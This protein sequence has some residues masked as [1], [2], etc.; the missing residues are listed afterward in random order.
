MANQLTDRWPKV[1]ELATDPPTGGL[2]KAFL[3]SHAGLLP[4]KEDRGQDGAWHSQDNP[5]TLD[6][7]AL[8]TK[9]L[10][11]KCSILSLGDFQ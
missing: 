5:A 8:A 3:H 10:K 7:S 4:G 9:L 6:P 1:F 2:A 11:R